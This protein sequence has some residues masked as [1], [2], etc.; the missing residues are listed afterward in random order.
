MAKGGQK[1]TP[2]DIKNDSLTVKRKMMYFRNRIY[3][4]RNARFLMTGEN[5]WQK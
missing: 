3:N 1:Y 2:V 5:E 4:I